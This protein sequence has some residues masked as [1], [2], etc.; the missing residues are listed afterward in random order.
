M[1]EPV[2]QPRAA[3]RT[4]GREQSQG[5]VVAA[6][7]LAGRAAP[8]GFRLCEGDSR[9]LGPPPVV[10]QRRRRRLPPA[11]RVEARRARF[12]PARVLRRQSVRSAAQSA[13]LFSLRRRRSCLRLSWSTAMAL[14]YPPFVVLMSHF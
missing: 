9:R 5:L 7:R 3:A 8:D 13:E 12:L 10:D 14:N 4:A 11:C 6:V 2:P 1:A